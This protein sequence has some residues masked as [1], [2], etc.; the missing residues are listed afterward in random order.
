R[1]IESIGSNRP[2]RKRLKRQRRNELHRATSHDHLDGILFFHQ[3]ADQLDRLVA[4]DSA[5]DP[6]NHVLW[7][8]VRHQR[9]I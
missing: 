1:Q 7:F 4:R 9:K 3:Q 5:A 6:E 2:G 8:V